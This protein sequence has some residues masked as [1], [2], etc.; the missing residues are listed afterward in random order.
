MDRRA[1]IST[2]SDFAVA[3]IYKKTL[4]GGNTSSF[5]PTTTTDNEMSTTNYGD[6][7]SGKE[8]S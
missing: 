2:Q 1:S 4:T 5:E 7:T 3:D 6:Q 8:Q